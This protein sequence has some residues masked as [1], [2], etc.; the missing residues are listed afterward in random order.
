M[1][2]SKTILLLLVVL[3]GTLAGCTNFF[4]NRLDTL[5]AWYVQDLVS[6]D[7]SQRSDLRTWLND[8]SWRTG[9]M[10]PPSRGLSGRRGVAVDG[11]TR[12]RPEFT[13]NVTIAKVGQCEMPGPLVY[14]TGGEDDWHTLAF[15]FVVIRGGGKTVVINTGLPEDLTALNALWDAAPRL[16]D[17]ITVVGAG[18][19]GCLCAFLAARIPG[20]DVE[21]VD[22]LPERAGVAHALGAQFATPES[23]TPERDL[24][25]HASGTEAGLRTAL[26]LCASDSSVIELSWYGDK[27]VALPLGRDF[28]VRRLDL[29]GSQVGTVSPNARRRFS[30]RSRL[31]LALTLCRDP[32]LDCLF[33]EEGELD[34]LPATLER[35]A[36][37]ESTVICHR[38]RYTR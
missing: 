19:V 17:R 25:I 33:S 6:L 35:L 31:E 34:A 8:V 14:R 20:S 22:V 10:T 26:S 32:A 37:R 16:G 36:Q 2:R 7:D 1:T 28:H 11:S 27:A 9:A 15:Y 24:V 3:A 23:A 21:L 38:I 30:H 12:A 29:R 4:Y 13:Y 18:S 5:A